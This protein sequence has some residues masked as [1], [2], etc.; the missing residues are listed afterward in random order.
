MCFTLMNFN[1]IALNLLFL[2]RFVRLNSKNL[3]FSHLMSFF[4]TSVISH[5]IVYIIKSILGMAAHHG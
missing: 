2:S 1:F 5:G 4:M 3:I